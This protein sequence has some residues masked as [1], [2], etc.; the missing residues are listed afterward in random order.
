MD[1][2]EKV[3]QTI[4]GYTLQVDEDSI[5]IKFNKE[6]NKTIEELRQKLTNYLYS[7]EDYDQL[8]IEIMKILFK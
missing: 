8:D 3:I 1:K 2:E 5:S 4:T 6:E 7:L